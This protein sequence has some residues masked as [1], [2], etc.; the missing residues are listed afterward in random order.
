M[1]VRVFRSSFLL[2]ATPAP[3]SINSLGFSIFPSTSEG[4][5]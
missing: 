3:T 5:S 1:R 4:D 2:I